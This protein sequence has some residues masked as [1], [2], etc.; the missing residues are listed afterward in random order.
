MT[1]HLC[2]VGRVLENIYVAFLH[3][4]NPKPSKLDLSSAKSA[5]NN[6][7]KLCEKCKNLSG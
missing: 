4:K 1:G 5:Y 7:V 3:Q 6:H 2:E